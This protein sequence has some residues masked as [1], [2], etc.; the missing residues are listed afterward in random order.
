MNNLELSRPQK[1]DLEDLLTYIKEEGDN[2][3]TF[4]EF[5]DI[6]KNVLK[7]ISNMKDE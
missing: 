1:K 6:L 4:G 5:T 2:Y 7:E 3:L